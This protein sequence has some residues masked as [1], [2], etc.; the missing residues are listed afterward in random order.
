MARIYMVIAVSTRCWRHVG[1]KV[2]NNGVPG[3]SRL[4]YSAAP[5]GWRWNSGRHMLNSV[6]RSCILGQLSTLSSVQVTWSVKRQA[7]I[8]TTRLEPLREV[9]YSL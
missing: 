3:A 8:N 4:R 5:I 1:A 7:K 6:W 2:L 9:S